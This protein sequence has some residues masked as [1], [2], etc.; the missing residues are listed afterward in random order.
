MD[1]LLKEAVGGHCRLTHT[2]LC[3]NLCWKMYFFT[4]QH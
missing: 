1:S 3:I 4:S 2:I